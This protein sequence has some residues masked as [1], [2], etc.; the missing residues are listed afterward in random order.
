[1]KRVAKVTF[2]LVFSMLLVGTAWAGMKAAST[3]YINTSGMYANGMLGASRNTADSVQYIGC[4]SW[5][6]ATGATYA[7][8]YAR[9][10]SSVYASCTT[11]AAPLV[12]VVHG[13]N[14]DSHLWF[15]WDASGNCSE[16]D[17][18]NVSQTPPKNP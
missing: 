16:I 4:Y 18:Y 6:Y 9:D 11:T 2:G 13:L 15:S 14:G 7:T 3:V 17:V 8:C 12:Q 5:A 10:A 1:M